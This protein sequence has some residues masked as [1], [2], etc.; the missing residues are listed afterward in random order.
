MKASG[1]HH[2]LE[3]LRRIDILTNTNHFSAGL[4]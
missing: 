1:I 2:H 4:S 3:R